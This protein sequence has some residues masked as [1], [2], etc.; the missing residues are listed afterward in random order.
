MD[1]SYTNVIDTHSNKATLAHASAVIVRR[2]GRTDYEATWR[3]MQAFTV[4][5]TADTA[6]EIWLTEHR[7][8]YTLGLAGRREHLLRDNGIAVVRTD[9]G[10]QIT[11]HGPGQLVVYVLL[12]LRRREDAG[13]AIPGD[14]LRRDVGGLGDDQ[15][16]GGA[17]HVVLGHHRRRHALERGARAR[18][19]RH[20]DAVGQREVAERER[21]EQVGHQSSPPGTCLIS[22][23]FSLPRSTLPVGFEG[24]SSTK[25]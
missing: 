19:R 23:S 12:D 6:D 21:A 4:S 25:K 8:V 11:F 24:I 16:G 7:S 14:R 22:R 17:L 5:R 15:A 9:R 10:G 20:D 3:A 18:E 1:N 13:R 2:L